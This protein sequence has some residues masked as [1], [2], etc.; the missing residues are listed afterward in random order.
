MRTRHRYLKLRHIKDKNKAL[1]VVILISIYRKS[2]DIATSKV[3]NL[4][5]ILF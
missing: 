3:T 4:W 5:L 1:N 2:V